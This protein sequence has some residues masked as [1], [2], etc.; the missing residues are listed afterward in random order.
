MRAVAAAAIVMLASAVALATPRADLARDFV[1]YLRANGLKVTVTKQTEDDLELSIAM[2]GHDAKPAIALENLER[3]VS[4]A[5]AGGASPAAAKQQ[6]FAKYL[7]TIRGFDHP[8]VTLAHDGEHVMPRLVPAGYVPS[9]DVMIAG[10]LGDTGLEIAY[11]IDAEGSVKYLS[12]SDAKSLGLAPDALRALAMKNLARTMPVEALRKL[13]AGSTFQVVK[14]MDSFDAA[15]LLLLQAALKKGESVAA[16][17]PDRDTLV[18][19]PVPADGNW[20]KL[21]AAAQVPSG[22]DHPLLKRP[23]L[24]TPDKIE[25]K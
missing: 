25:A 20:E 15:R 22:G 4:D 14:Q 5:V 21:R 8:P 1:A 2:G 19:A 7:A 12:R 24:V 13:V 11:V 10:K 9:A 6:L 17:V 3:Y 23:L 18:V 16:L